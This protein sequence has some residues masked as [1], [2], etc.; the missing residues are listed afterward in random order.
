MLASQK[1]LEPFRTLIPCDYWKGKGVLDIPYPWI[2]PGAIA[3][4]D[5]RL[6]SDFNVLE[7]GS[8]GSTLWFAKKCGSVKSIEP[9]FDDWYEAVLVGLQRMGLEFYNKVDL[10]HVSNE[11]D[12]YKAIA[13]LVTYCAYDV[14]MVDTATII[15]KQLVLE[16]VY[17]VVAAGGLLVVDNYGETT[18]H[19]TAPVD[20]WDKFFFDDPH[21][22]GSGTLIAVR[23]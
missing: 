2:T 10:R 13:D 21:W 17:P 16:A 4:L 18:W 5:E 20:E 1:Q 11:K 12:Y 9:G 6:K 14:V 3:F 23:L 8:G 15:S 19:H 7:I 22:N